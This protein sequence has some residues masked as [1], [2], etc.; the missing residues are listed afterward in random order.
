MVKV[1]K[2][3]FVHNTGNKVLDGQKYKVLECKGHGG[4]TVG[5]RVL[6]PGQI[7]YDFEWTWG[8]DSLRAAIAKKRC[9][10]VKEKS[11]ENSSKKE[12]KN[13]S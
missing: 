12:K 6:K 8:E 1:T 3:E 5:P 9:K 2:R 11:K 13:D 7:F 10:I 4:L